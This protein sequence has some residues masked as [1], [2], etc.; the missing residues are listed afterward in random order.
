MTSNVPCEKGNDLYRFTLQFFQKLHFLVFDIISPIFCNTNFL[1]HSTYSNHIKR[2]R[3]FRTLFF[4]F[5][6][7]ITFK[8]SEIF[9]FF[10]EF[11]LHVQCVQS[12]KFTHFHTDSALHHLAIY[13]QTGT[14][15]NFRLFNILFSLWICFNILKPIV[16]TV[17]QNH[18][19]VNL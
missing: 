4:S 18:H 13:S 12:S 5:K 15:K 9:Q 6:I 14:F 1:H 10:Q 2:F 8:I 17:G 7:L 11:F 19:H 16:W 3:K